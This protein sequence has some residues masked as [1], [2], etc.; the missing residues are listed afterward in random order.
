MM[1]GPLIIGNALLKLD[2][3]DSTNTY[4]HTLLKNQKVTEGLVVWAVQ[5]THG[6]G[7]PGTNWHSD[8]G[9]S[10]TCSVILTPSFLPAEEQFL[11]NKALSCGL[12]QY[13]ELRIPQ[14]SAIKW[15]NDLYIYNRKTGGVLIENS[16][17]GRRI[18][19]SIVGIGINFNQPAFPGLPQ[20]TSLAM[21]TGRQYNISDE[22]H[23]LMACLDRWYL[24][25]R[26]GAVQQIQEAYFNCLWGKDELIPYIA[27]EEKILGKVVGVKD[28]GLLQLQLDNGDVREFGFKEIRYAPE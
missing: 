21:H 11:L 13:L 12:Y 25:L 16:I 8:A 14:G 18:Q 15:P 5:Q 2:A 28:N 27:G 7:Q 1:P 3:V 4:A 26:Q 9:Q 17:T 19:S 6:R 23:A 20:A 10:L 24:L 22:L